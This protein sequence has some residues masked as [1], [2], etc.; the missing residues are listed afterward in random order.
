[1]SR[2]TFNLILKLI[3]DVV[4]YLF[5][6]HT[7]VIWVQ[8]TLTSSPITND[9][10]RWTLA[11]ALVCRPPSSTIISGGWNERGSAAK[12]VIGVHWLTLLR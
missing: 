7:I 11:L 9:S 1:M 5:S 12:F 4:T 2:C 10:E 6:E 8:D 3:L